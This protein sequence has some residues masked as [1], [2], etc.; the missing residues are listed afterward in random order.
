LRF[1]EEKKIPLD[2]VST[3]SYNTKTVLD[4][5]G[6]KKRRILDLNYL[7]DNVRNTRKIADS[8]SFKDIQLD[9]TEINSS[10]SSRDP[11][12]DSYQNA[13]FILNTLKN[14]DGVAHSMSYWTFT[15]IF[16]EAGPATSAFHGGFGLLNLQGIRKP[17]F[18]AYQF[19]S[20]LG[21]TKLANTDRWS[22][23][24][25]DK[26]GVQALFWNAKLPFSGALFSDSLFR[27]NPAPASAG[28]VT[29]D[30]K[31]IPAGKYELQVFRV[32]Y[33]QNDAF[34]AW[35][36]MGSPANITKAQEAALK[37]EASGKPVISKEISITNGNYKERFAMRENDIYFIKLTRLKQ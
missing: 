3:H 13:A 28:D 17:T 18:F 11:L 34:S 22:W 30:I 1:C 9:Y 37:K 23:V 29:V 27:L 5:F 32:G 31:N 15:D 36:Q 8:T 19:L 12:H 20:E 16:E 14:T 33:Q 24:T 4:E 6:T 2:F 21:D 10:P 25:K 35:L 7:S 26:E